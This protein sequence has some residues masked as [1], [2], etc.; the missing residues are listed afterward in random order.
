MHLPLTKQRK[1]ELVAEYA[2]MLQQSKAVIFTEYRGLDNKAMT[3]VRRKVR[4]ANGRYRV[5]KLSL[6]KLALERA[7]YPVPTDLIGVPVAVGFCYQE[8]AGV[9]KALTEYAKDSEVF[10]VRG[11]LMGEQQM[12]VS[13]IKTIADLPPLEVLRAQILGLLD[14]PAANLVGVLQAGVAA[15]INVIHA[16]VQKGESA[17]A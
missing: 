10:V 14:A 12:T 2:D 17:A 3:E 1:E 8:I 5:A 11:G 9:A 16:F 4:E 7:G 13:E 15:P 6:F